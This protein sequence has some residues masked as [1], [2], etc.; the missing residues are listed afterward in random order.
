MS[1]DAQL[2]DMIRLKQP[3]A[4]PIE[5]WQMLPARQRKAPRQTTAAEPGSVSTPLRLRTTTINVSVTSLTPDRHKVVLKCRKT[6]KVNSPMTPKYNASLK[7]KTPGGNSK[8]RTPPKSG[9][10]KTP[11]RSP[12]GCRFIPNRASMDLDYS[13]YLLRKKEAEEEGEDQDSDMLSPSGREC[14]QALLKAISRNRG[15]SGQRNVLSFS[16]ST[17]SIA[18]GMEKILCENSSVL[19][20]CE[21]SHL[22]LKVETIGVGIGL[23]QLWGLASYFHQIVC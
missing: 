11:G 12:S 21:I 4:A 18:E 20:R 22:K 16:I 14:Q 6:P 17:P 19:K 13:A 23:C 1:S 8:R 3:P 15:K 5:R 10:K 7:R 2:N 9:K